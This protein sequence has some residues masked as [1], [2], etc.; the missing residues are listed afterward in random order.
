MGLLMK[1]SKLGFGVVGSLDIATVSEIAKRAEEIGLHSLWFNETP[2]GDAIERMKVATS[3]TNRLLVG[4]GVINVDR[5][6]AN[7]IVAAVRSRELDEARILIGIGA[8]AKPSPLQTVRTAIEELRQEL[9]CPIIVGSLG[10]R[11]RQLG[12]EF[13]NGLLFNWLTPEHAAETTQVM[14]EQAK[15]AGNSPVL[16]ATYIRTALG[17]AALESLRTEASKY[18]SIPSYAA[19]FERLGITAMESAVYGTSAEDVAKGV[20]A[21]DGTVDHA[22]VRAITA[23]D[24]T[25]DYLQLLDAIA[26]L[27]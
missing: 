23:T 16:S 2:D 11:M 19:N 21:F 10:P 18:S 5:T 7:A 12:A 22:I 27:A 17:E 8:S 24:D 9:S 1:T 15:A 26:P 13:G 25:G 14:R 4:S 3:V 20:A 6:S